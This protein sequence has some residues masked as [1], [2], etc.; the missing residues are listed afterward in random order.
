V[1][2]ARCARLGWWDGWGGPVADEADLELHYRLEL[3]R[4]HQ[5]PRPASKEPTGGPSASLRHEW[6]RPKT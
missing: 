6:A 3:V 4:Q 2:C 1:W 5:P